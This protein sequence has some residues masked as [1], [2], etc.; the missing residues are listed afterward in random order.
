[1]ATISIRVDDKLKEQLMRAS[2][3]IGLS[4]SSLFTVWAKSFLRTWE[5]TLH[6]RWDNED[7]EI[8]QNA[9]M[10]KKQFKKSEQSGRWTLVL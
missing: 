6:V 9:Q 10:L 3:E 8:F 2:D 5:I 7:E 1:M 4:M